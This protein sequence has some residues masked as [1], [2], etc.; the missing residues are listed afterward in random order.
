MSEVPLCK[1]RP[2]PRHRISGRMSIRKE[3]VWV[4]YERR[5]F[6]NT[7]LSSLE[8]HRVNT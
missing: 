2:T 4:F 7:H 6:K 8:W 5:G 3:V 1:G